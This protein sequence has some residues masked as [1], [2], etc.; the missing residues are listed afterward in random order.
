MGFIITGVVIIIGTDGVQ[1]NVAF[2]LFFQFC[3]A[4]ATCDSCILQLTRAAGARYATGV[5]SV[6][7]AL[8]NSAPPTDP[9]MQN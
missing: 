6:L 9:M 8:H 3:A 1:P 7:A 2:N 5:T 4:A